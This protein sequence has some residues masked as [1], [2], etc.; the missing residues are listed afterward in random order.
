MPPRL[1]GHRVLEFQ[2]VQQ[3]NLH[4]TFSL[5]TNPDK[6]VRKN[7]DHTKE[8]SVFQLLQIGKTRLCPLTGINRIIPLI[9]H[10]FACL[11]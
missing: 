11:W 5:E 9:V 8:Q 10:V 7:K 1:S 2:T 4:G 3:F 6:P